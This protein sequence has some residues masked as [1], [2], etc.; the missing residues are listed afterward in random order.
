MDSILITGATGFIGRHLVS[1]LS[2]G[3]FN[4]RLALR[5]K[6]G[7]LFNDKDIDTC[8]YDSLADNNDYDKL[9]GDI[10]F[11]IHLAGLAHNPES[12]HSDYLRLNSEASRAL[13]GEA[14]VRGIKR[15]LYM[16]TVKVHGESSLVKDDRVQAIKETSP[17]LPSDAYSQSKLAGEHALMEVCDDR[18]MEFVILRPPLVY[19]PG[20]KANFQTLLKA[21]AKAIPLPLADIGNQRSLIYVENLC[22]IIEKVLIS[23]QCRNQVYLVKDSDFSTTEL[24]TELAEAL[25]QSPRL[26]RVPPSVLKLVASLLNKSS[27]IDRLTQSLLIDDN[28]LRRDLRWHPPVDIKTAIKLTSEWYRQNL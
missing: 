27:S 20:V 6:Q 9:L 24:I 16:S 18:G 14:S 2:G 26:F 25:G 12:N 21:V 13:A 1:R 28:K 17:L 19:G 23:S 8:R 7:N 15:F 11:V 22:D 3:E 10:D 4:I 5:D